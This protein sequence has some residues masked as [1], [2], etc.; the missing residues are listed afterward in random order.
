MS[1]LPPPP[2]DLD[3]AAREE[4]SRVV[5]RLDAMGVLKNVDANSL[6]AYVRCFSNPINQRNRRQQP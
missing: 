6:A 5:R 1:N 3:V 2:A 4:W